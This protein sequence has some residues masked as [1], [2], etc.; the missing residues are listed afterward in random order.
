M[1]VV[2]PTGPQ[3]Y[4]DLW[5][6]IL[7]GAGPEAVHFDATYPER[8]LGEFCDEAGLQCL[9]LLDELR[10]A[11]RQSDERLYFDDGRRHFNDEGN[12]VA[13]E[14]VADFLNRELELGLG[15]R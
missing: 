8:R 1:L 12:A 9:I 4:D 15:D 5:A 14:F 10:A 6:E 13:V 3:I 11:A 2:L 7:A